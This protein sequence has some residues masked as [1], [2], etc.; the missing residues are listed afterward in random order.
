MSASEV[1][2]I[3]F[4]AVGLPII[5][6]LLVATCLGL[7]CRKKM[8]KRKAAKAKVGESQKAINPVL[9]EGK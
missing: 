3:W 1:K 6:L 8:R 5:V 4:L 9:V 2:G 7:W